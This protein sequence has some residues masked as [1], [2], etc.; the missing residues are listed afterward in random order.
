MDLDFESVIR[1][2]RQSL[3]FGAV[4]RAPHLARFLILT[5]TSILPKQYLTEMNPNPEP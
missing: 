1:E 3:D 4:S 2:F 5:Q